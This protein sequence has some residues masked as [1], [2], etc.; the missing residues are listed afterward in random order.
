M[1]TIAGRASVSRATADDPV[2]ER[3][4]DHFAKNQSRH[5]A[6]DAQV[7]W[8][9]P[10]HLPDAVRTALVRSFQRF[11]LGEGGD[12]EHLL[13]KSSGCS[14]AQQEAL[15]M[16][17]EEEQLHSELFKRGLQHLGAATRHG[18]WSDKVFTFL[19]RSLGLRTEL[20]L[21][22]AA[23]A[24]VMPYFVALSRSGPDAV[25]QAI[26]TRIARDEDTMWHSRKNSYGSGSLRRRLP[27]R[28]SFL[29]H[30]GS[31]RSPPPQ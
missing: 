3:W 31:S 12:G 14:P 4:I 7:D 5:A 17:V 11:E 28:P 6:I 10:A 29:Q 16:L 25:I 30:G 19:R 1:K 8:D 18:H 9:T 2:F 27:E 20:A 24:V 23:E 26:G 22:L 13:R 15:R 21:F